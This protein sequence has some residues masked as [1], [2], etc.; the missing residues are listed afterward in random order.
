[1]AANLL[2]ASALELP[3]IIAVRCERVADGVV[4][5]VLATA[6]LEQFEIKRNGESALVELPARLPQAPLELP[7]ALPPLRSI[8]FEPDPTRP[9]LRVTWAPGTTLDSR[10]EGSLLTLLFSVQDQPPASRDVE[11]LYPLLFPQ[12]G[13][14]QAVVP[15][16]AQQGAAQE[17]EPEGLAL[18]PFRVRPSVAARYVDATATLLDTPQPVSAQYLEIQPALALATSSLTGARLSFSYEPR[19]R[20][21]EDGIPVLS[22]PSHTFTGALDFPIGSVVRVSLSDQL[23]RGALEAEV[24]D[25]GREYFFDLGRFRRNQITLGLRTDTMGRY[26]WD[27]GAGRASE[28]I[29]QSA[30]YFDNIRES[31]FFGPRYE[32]GDATNATLRYEFERVLPPAERPVVEARAHSLLAGLEGDVG[33][34]LRA[35][36]TAGFRSESH[37]RAA[38]PGDR[39]RG[40]TLQA[41]LRRD[42]G[43]GGSLTLGGNRASHLSAFE[44]NGFYVSNRVEASLTVPLPMSARLS[45]SANHHR[46]DYRLIAQ[47]L[48]EPRRDRLFGWSAGLARS[49]TRWSH[50][51]AD[52]YWDRRASNVP[53]LTVRTH[54]FVAQLGLGGFTS[55]AVR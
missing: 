36:V 5:K 3:E 27:F 45:V 8:A 44:A 54:S 29:T 51:R 6:A 31:I 47:G 48:S 52:Y 7:Q 41:S 38:S 32:L 35:T 9:R 30:G 20:S 25:P 16:G 12:S 50:V 1:M 43:N 28:S 11:R 14:E 55:A 15:S 33:T 34:S 17:P 49:I 2:L 23:R 18:G 10:V 19:F 37:P 40:L 22:E 39:F 21:S 24:L 26:D 42:F 53:G 13:S 4:I 46:N